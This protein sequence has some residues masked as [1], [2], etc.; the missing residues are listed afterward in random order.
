MLGLWKRVHALNPASVK[1]ARRKP[2]EDVGR[3]IVRVHLVRIQLAASR[4]RVSDPLR[5]GPVNEV[6]R[7]AGLDVPAVL[8][9]PMVLAVLPSERV[10]ERQ[11]L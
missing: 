6:L 5:L 7:R 2:Q 4:G 9:V 8:E 10:L 11:V 3:P 1:V